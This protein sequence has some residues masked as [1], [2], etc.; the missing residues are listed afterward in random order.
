[1]PVAS[2]SA[3]RSTSARSRRSCGGAIRGCTSSPRTRSRPSSASTS[4][5]RR[6]PR[7]RTSGRSSR[8]TCSALA[9]QVATAGLPEPLVMRSSGGVATLAGGGRASRHRSSS[10]GPR[11]AWSGPASSH[12]SPASRTR[13]HST[14]AERRPTS[15]CCRRTGRSA[16]ASGSSAASRSACRRS[17]C[18][19][20]VR[21]AARS[22]GATRA[23]RSASARRARA[24]NP[25]RPATGGA[26]AATVTDANLLLGASAARAAGGLVLD[27]GAAERRLAGIDPAAVVEVVNAEMLRALR[28]VSVERGSRSARLRARRL[29]RG[30]AAARVRAR[31]GARDR[32]RA[33]SR[34]RPACSRLSVSWPATSGA[35]RAVVRLPARRGRRAAGCR[36]RPTSATAGS[37][38]S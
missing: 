6:R 20:S 33:R 29:R 24:R 21:A 37:R 1:M 11:A 4:A 22:S 34:T 17:T 14:W 32:D 15:A 13:S 18:T 16:R 36:A 12:G 25:V 30:G 38:S 23:A 5:P 31:R 8:A 2:R 27:R 26:G 3:I 28:V 35:T 19:R 7:T 10:P 9:E